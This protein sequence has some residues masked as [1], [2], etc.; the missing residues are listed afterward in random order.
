MTIT[1]VPTEAIELDETQVL[2]QEAKQRRRRRWIA[3]GIGVA[4]VAVLVLVVSVTLGP[5]GG[6]GTA[7]PVN[8]VGPAVGRLLQAKSFTMINDIETANPANTTPT[9]GRVVAV[10]NRNGADSLAEHSANPTAFAYPVGDAGSTNQMN[11]VITNRKMYIRYG[12]TWIVNTRPP[13]FDPI[14]YLTLLPVVDSAPHVNVDGNSFQVVDPNLHRLNELFG[15]GVHPDLFNTARITGTTN[16]NTVTSISLIA[17][18]KSEH[19]KETQQF[20]RVG[21]SPVVRLPT[22]N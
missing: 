21:S 3:S 11:W 20:R 16:G 1:D 2:F 15:G 7:V 19:L 8:P 6:S 9:A 5:V 17:S 13:S 22:A 14:S 4:I 10:F 18:G 12:T